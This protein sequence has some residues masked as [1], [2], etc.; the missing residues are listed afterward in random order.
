VRLAARELLRRPSRFLVAGGALT[1]LTL[2]LLFLGGLLDGLFLGSTGALRAQH[3]DGVVFSSDARSSVLRSDINPGLRAAVDDVDGVTATGG[4]GVA[5]LGVQVPGED[6]IAGGAVI[7]YELAGDGLPA[8]PAPGTAWA[9]RR[10]EAAGAEVGDV[11]LVGPAEVP[12]ELAGW[13]EDTSYLLQA[14]L[15]VEPGTWRQ[16]QGANRPDDPVAPG[17]FQVLVV[18][19]DGGADPAGVLAGIDR[20]TA[21]ATE[22]LSL[23]EAVY[24]LPGLRA[25]DATFTAIIFTT[26]F[27]AGLVVALFFA[28][29]TLER[30]GL[31]AVLKA[32]GTPDRA[33][34]LGVVVQSAA[35]ALGA[36]AVGGL[37]TALLAQLIP[38]GVPVQFTP[39]RA[40]FVAAG[41]VVTAL[42]GG[43]VSLRR[44]VRIDPAA[45]IGAGG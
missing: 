34:V 9:D 5:L 42:A 35:V 1:L 17:A 41:L 29:V 22:T 43:L 45:A 27:V 21:G 8:P 33:L 7:G 10:L 14:S 18:R 36:F 31:Y 38:P 20:A 39:G 25:Q 2:L 16:V 11:V 30:T 19:V 24:A 32:V 23:H 6:A 28:L 40:A 37:L 26:L 15:W 12:L 44:I 13:V 3:A 4:V